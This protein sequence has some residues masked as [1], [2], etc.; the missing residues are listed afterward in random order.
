MI[1]TLD[2]E[3]FKCFSALRFRVSALTLLTGY[4]A[5]GKSSAVQPLL[6]LAQSTRH[7]PLRQSII[8]NGP[9]IRLGTVGDVLPTNKALSNLVFKISEKDI[10]FTWRA[11]AKAGERKFEVTESISPELELL[12]IISGNLVAETKTKLL[13]TL[14]TLSYLS[15]IRQGPSD[16]YPTPESSE[17]SAVDVGIDGRYAPYW[18]DQFVDEE[19]GEHRRHPN[20]PASSF[21]KQADAW[22][23][24]LF[25]GAKVNVQHNAQ[26]ALYA[27]QF[28]NS[29]FGDWRRPSNVGYGFSYAFPI[30]VALLAAAEEQVIVIDSP[31]AHLHPYAQSQMGRI[32]SHFA[33]AGVQ[34]IVETHSDHF[35]NGVRLAVKD[36]KL[37]PSDLQV[38]FFTGATDSGHGVLSLNIDKDGRIADW[39]EGFFDQSERDI[40]RLS[41]WEQT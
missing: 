38:H 29:D 16:A 28:R 2:I 40:A 36:N 11:I 39:P 25:P 41:G 5:G 7:N 20:E 35:L 15:A 24:T 26:M 8:L 1:S 17:D 9:H 27:L 21:R 3:N 10:E 23:S 31:E 4:N 22:L 12:E 34:I 14:T 6:L 32:I 13:A 30:I 37:A 33:A 18:Y 19:V